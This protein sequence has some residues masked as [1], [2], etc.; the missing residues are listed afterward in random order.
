MFSSL[1]KMLVVAASLCSHV[2]GYYLDES[3][4][5]KMAG[6]I[7]VAMAQNYK[8]AI[9]ALTSLVSIRSRFTRKPLSEVEKLEE[10]TLS[11]FLGTL[12]TDGRPDPDTD[13]W[14]FTMSILAWVAKQATPPDG[15][16]PG[17]PQPPPAPDTANN[18]RYGDLDYKSVVVFCDTSRYKHVQEPVE[19]KDKDRGYHRLLDPHIGVFVRSD[20]LD[21]D[22]MDQSKA[23]AWAWPHGARKDVPGEGALHKSHPGVIQLSPRILK[24]YERINAQPTITL[25]TAAPVLLWQGPA[26]LD[27]FADNLDFTLFHELTHTVQGKRGEEIKDEGGYGWEKAVATSY[28]IGHLNADNI[29]YFAFTTYLIHNDPPIKFGMNGQP[30]QITKSNGKRGLLNKFEPNSHTMPDE[31]SCCADEVVPTTLRT[32]RQAQ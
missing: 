24:M 3:C 18:R 23:L 32:I 8:I 11:R 4:D 2:K 15:A 10:E 5:G 12:T 17:T 16:K 26:A 14:D 27:K 13:E 19:E 31:S 29:V 6:N 7:K 1:V 25:D 28:R 9:R 30:E 22:I 20:H 21:A